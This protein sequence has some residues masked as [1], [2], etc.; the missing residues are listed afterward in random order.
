MATPKQ[1]VPA[2]RPVVFLQNH[3]QIANSAT[4]A[5]TCFMLLMPG[6]PMLFQGQEFAASSV[7]LLGLV[8]ACRR[9]ASFCP[10]FR[11]S[12]PWP[13]RR[14]AIPAKD[15]ARSAAGYMASARAV[16]LSVPPRS[17]GFAARRS[18]LLG[19]EARC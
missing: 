19:G 13:R 8:R 18:D 1:V 10:S 5:L 9:G 15:R 6:I 11:A 16:R 12:H 7:S 4:G 14:L 17:A 3:D 2:N